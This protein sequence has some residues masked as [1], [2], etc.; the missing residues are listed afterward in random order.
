MQKHNLRNR[1][2]MVIFP[3]GRKKYLFLFRF[4]F[5]YRAFFKKNNFWGFNMYVHTYFKLQE[6][7]IPIWMLFNLKVITIIAQG[8]KINW[9][10]YCLFCAIF[11]F[12]NTSFALQYRCK[13]GD[14]PPRRWRSRL[15]LENAIRDT[16]GL[17]GRRSCQCC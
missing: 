4:H 15:S 1:R 11:Q 2:K 5:H 7:Y 12:F 10:S 14:C 3:K 8:C 17:L 9:Y 13:R 6:Q 16:V